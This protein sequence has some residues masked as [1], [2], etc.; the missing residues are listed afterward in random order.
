MAIRELVLR[1]AQ[2]VCIFDS[3]DTCA[4]RTGEHMPGVVAVVLNALEDAAPKRLLCDSTCSV[5]LLLTSSDS[6]A[7]Y[8]CQ[9][10]G[11]TKPVRRDLSPKLP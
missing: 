5:T 7:G 4:G 8:L 3:V 1:R 2:T 11:N 10:P 9:A 6:L